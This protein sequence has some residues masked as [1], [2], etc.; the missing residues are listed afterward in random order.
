MQLGGG[1]NVRVAHSLSIR[2]L[3]I[4]YVHT[5]LPNNNADSQND[6]RLAFGVSYRFGRR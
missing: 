5:N 2:A 3:E 6:L 1:I 4:D